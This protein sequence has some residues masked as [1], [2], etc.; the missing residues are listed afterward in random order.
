M[1]KK[2]NKSATAKQN[3][4]NDILSALIDARRNGLSFSVIS[5]IVT[6]VMDNQPGFNNGPKVGDR[7]YII[8]AINDQPKSVIGQRG[9]II[10][11]I[12][13]SD[14]QFSYYDIQVD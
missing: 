12:A 11:V 9:T 13:D 7:V 8:K 14:P 6:E 1:L 10:Q 3:L 2:A 4:R 5:K